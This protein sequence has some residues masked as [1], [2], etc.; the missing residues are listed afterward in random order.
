[1]EKIKFDKRNYVFKSGYYGTW[2]SVLNHI[3]LHK[4]MEKYPN[5]CDLELF[6]EEVRNFRKNLVK[7]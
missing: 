7:K 5:G 2:E 6:I 4:L 1:M 3:L